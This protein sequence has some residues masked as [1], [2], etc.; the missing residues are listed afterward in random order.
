MQAFVGNVESYSTAFDT[1]QKHEQAQNSTYQP[2]VNKD[3]QIQQGVFNPTTFGQGQK[4][5]R[6]FGEVRQKLI[7]MN[8][9]KSKSVVTASPMSSRA[10]TSEKREMLQKLS[11]SQKA[12]PTKATSVGNMASMRER[13]ISNFLVNTV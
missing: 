9:N 8:L 5:A 13:L 2:V 3:I 4:S 7:N 1:I 6:N 11:L 10:I 12:V